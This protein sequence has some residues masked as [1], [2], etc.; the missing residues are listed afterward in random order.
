MEPGPQRGRAKMH[1]HRTEVVVIGA[2]HAGLAASYFLRAHGIDHVVFERGRIGES[3]HSQRWDSFTLNTPNWCSLLPGEELDGRD[4]DAFMSGR[5]FIDALDAYAARL[6]L[7]VRENAG[8]VALERALDG[9]GFLVRVRDG[10]GEATWHCK[11]AVIASGIMSR[12][13]WPAIGARVTDG[14]RQLHAADFRS[15]DA[16]PE[17]GVLVVGSGQSGCQI[18]EDLVDAGRTVYLATSRVGR[19]PRRYRGKDVFYWLSVT[20]ILDV[21]TEAVADP[22]MLVAPQPQV[23]GTGPRGHS[24]SLQQL[25][26]R[27]VTILGRLET[28]NGAVASFSD[29]AAENVRFADASS[30]NRK[31]AIDVFIAKNGIDAP[32][33]ADDEGD[34]P[35]PDAASASR[36]LSLDLVKEN[37]TSV[38]WTTGFDGDFSWI[39]LPVCDA[40]GKPIHHDGISPVPGV[41]F[42]GLPWLRMRK[43]GI[44]HGIAEDA[45]FIAAKIIRVR[46]SK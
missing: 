19:A 29:D 26:R 37:I 16:L 34:R 7:P 23:S 46:N 9:D 21:P 41:H 13:K 3:W 44:I 22:A 30:A 31:N 33:N 18:T 43:S 38:I 27:G 15:A 25:H 5:Q 6:Q 40:Q 11:Q 20:G 32:P 14:V 42:I 35:D 2:G 12:P 28:I 10:C 39:R 24:V 36:I 45:G 17:G 8:V 1:D 4:P